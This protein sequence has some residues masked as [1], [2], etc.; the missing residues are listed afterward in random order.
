MD[1]VCGVAMITLGIACWLARADLESQA[2]KGLTIALL[3]H[4]VGVCLIPFHAWRT[5]ETAGA[6]LWL[7]FYAMRC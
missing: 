2:T 1:Q 4:N 5:F 6:G 7:T 3:L